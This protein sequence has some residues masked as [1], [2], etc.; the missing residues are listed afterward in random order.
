MSQREVPMLKL[1]YKVK[2]LVQFLLKECRVCKG[3]RV[4]R[5]CTEMA[6]L[7]GLPLYTTLIKRPHIKLTVHCVRESFAS[8]KPPLVHVA[9]IVCVW[10]SIYSKLI[11][12]P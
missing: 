11:W 9:S 1:T 10:A 6:E 3:V 7:G 12:S 4:C 8:Y 5:V 2:S